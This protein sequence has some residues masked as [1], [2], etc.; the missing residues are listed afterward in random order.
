[1]T[2]DWRVVAIERAHQL[3]LLQA[4]Y[5]DALNFTD[6]RHE[7]SVVPP[8]FCKCGWKERWTEQAKDE[9]WEDELQHRR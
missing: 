1:M 4:D 6:Q 9:E 3:A 5:H 7:V 2:K 8:Y